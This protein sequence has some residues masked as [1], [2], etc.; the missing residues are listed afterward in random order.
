[1]ETIGSKIDDTHFK[2]YNKVKHALPNMKPAEIKKVLNTRLHDKRMKLETIKPYM[3]KIFERVSGCYFHDLLVQPR[4]MNPLYYH[5]FIGANN[6]YAF[7]YPVND[8]SAKTAVDTLKKFVNDAKKP[9]HKLTSDGECAFNSKQFIDACQ[10]NGIMLKIIPDGAHSTMGI[11]DRFIRTLRDMNQPKNKSDSQQYSKDYIEIT[12]SKMKSL[13]SSYNNSYHNSIKCSPK[14]MYNN[15]ELEQ[16]YI[17]KCIRERNIQSAVTNFNIPVGT[18]VRYKMNDIDINGHKRR[19]QLS[20]EKYLINKR[21]GNRY[22]LEAADGK[23]ISKSRF[24]LIKA[25][26]NDPVGLTFEQ[27]KRVNPESVYTG[28]LYH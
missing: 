15:T 10:E 6:R 21:L 8:K 4:G 14:E 27:N 3:R 26:D 19:S 16:D 20:R 17:K 2:T 24:E 28:I 7:A 13:I 1:M 9:I 25:D 23:I 12:P 18:Y 5:I 11:V 22:L